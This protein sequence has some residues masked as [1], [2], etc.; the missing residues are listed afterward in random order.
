MLYVLD[1]ILENFMRDNQQ[2][3]VNFMDKG[4]IGF[5]KIYSKRNRG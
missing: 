2:A 1:K 5:H 3:Y 4:M